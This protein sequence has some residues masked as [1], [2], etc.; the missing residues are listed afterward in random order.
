MMNGVINNKKAAEGIE[1]DFQLAVKDLVPYI[2]DIIDG[3]D[4][5]NISEL[6]GPIS[7]DY[8]KFNA[9]SDM[10]NVKAAGDIFR[11]VIPKL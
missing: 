4:I 7:R 3:F 5:P 2:N 6:Y 1:I 11:K 9:Q 10:D 8:V